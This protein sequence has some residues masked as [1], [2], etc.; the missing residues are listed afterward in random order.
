M[1]FCLWLSGPMCSQSVLKI[2]FKDHIPGSPPDFSFFLFSTQKYPCVQVK[3][4]LITTDAIWTPYQFVTVNSLYSRIHFF[5][6][7]VQTILRSYT[8]NCKP[9]F[10]VASGCISKVC[11]WLTPNHLICLS[12]NHC[13]NPIFWF[14]RDDGFLYLCFI[15]IIISTHLLNVN[16]Y[17]RMRFGKKIVISWVPSAVFPPYNYPH[18]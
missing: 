5:T 18:L 1:L 15:F 13:S 11:G 6:Y 12:L 2:A 4:L 8:A 7:R 9:H 3:I 17:N 10:E 14:Q 16:K